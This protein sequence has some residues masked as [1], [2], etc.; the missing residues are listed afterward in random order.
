[1][2]AEYHDSPQRNT[3]NLS[4]LS[5]EDRRQLEAGSG[6]SPEVIAARGYYTARSPSALP[7]A[8]PRWQRRLGLVVPGHSPSGATFHQYKP[9]TR[10]RRRSGEG[11]KYETPQDAPVMLDVNPIMLEEVRYG[12]GELW[13][14]EGAKKVDALAS[15]G[16]PAVGLTGVHMFAVPGTKGTEPLACWRHVRLK[17]RTVIIAFDADAKTNADVQ[18][19]LRRLVAMLEGLGAA[20]LVVYVPAVDD[21]TKAGVD[22]YKA[23]GLPLE[24]L[25]R[26]GQPYTPLDVGRERMRRDVELAAVVRACRRRLEEMPANGRAACSNRAAM[27]D[28]ISTGV[29]SGKVKPDGLLVIRSSLDGAA[30][31]RMSERAWWKAIERLEAAGE[32]RRAKW[33][34][35]GDRSGAYLLTPWGGGSAECAYYRREATAGEGQEGRAREERE[36]RARSFPLSH[37]PADRSMHEP[38]APEEV[39]ALRWPKV[40]HTWGRRNGRRIV[41]DSDYIARVGKQ[42]EEVIR[43]LLEHGRTSAPELLEMFGARTTRLRDFKRRRIE[44]LVVRGIVAAHGEELAPAW[45]EALERARE[46][47]G[48]IEDNRLQAEKVERRKLE[49]REHFKRV[50]RGEVPKADPTPTPRGKEHTRRILERHRSRWQAERVEAERQKVGMTAVVFL[51]DELAGVSGVR[52]QDLRQRWIERGGKTEDLTRAVRDPSS[53]F[54]FERDPAD[55]HLYVYPADSHKQSHTSEARGPAPVVPLNREPRKVN[56]VYVHGPEC[57]CWLCEDVS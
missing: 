41:V 10:I 24:G 45:R 43:Y 3:T 42:G 29:R 2:E 14:T 7:D 5:D 8:F 9:R 46:E 48:E 22:D 4:N 53:P 11:P 15:W 36:E 18:E 12:A 6:I 57:A 44:P 50:R 35:K 25:R 34:P 30:S 31:S 56:G 33:G 28:L 27:R 13:I 52:F 19:A 37:A 47:G 26:R 32:L 17:G 40:V 20:I 54:R 1:M 39:P 21:D 23:A 55:D 51:S 16:V 49:R 38:R